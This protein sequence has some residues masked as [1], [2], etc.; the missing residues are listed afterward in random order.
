M[1]GLMEKASV[2]KSLL[3][4]L[5]SPSEIENENRGI[6]LFEYYQT[7][8]LQNCAF[9][10]MNMLIFV[11]VNKNTCGFVTYVSVVSKGAFGMRVR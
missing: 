8:L 10:S 1:Y 2:T 3:P 4:K 11:T 5:E 7:V 6:V 9:R